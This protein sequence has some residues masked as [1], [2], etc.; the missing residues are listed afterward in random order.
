[1]SISEDENISMYL[2][3]NQENNIYLYLEIFMSHNSI[4]H[5]GRHANR[6]PLMRSLFTEN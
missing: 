2:K 3:I 1:M 4:R 6:D 5:P